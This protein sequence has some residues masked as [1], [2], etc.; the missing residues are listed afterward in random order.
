MNRS[1]FAERVILFFSLLTISLVSFGENAEPNSPPMDPS[2]HSA[3]HPKQNGS[4]SALEKALDSNHKGT[5]SAQSDGSAKSMSSMGTGTPGGGMMDMMG[6]QMMQMMGS[7]MGMM[8]AATMGSQKMG[9]DTKP[10]ELPGFPGYS[11]IY[12]V[13]ATGFFLDHDRMIKLSPEQ[14]EKL[15]EIKK[16]TLDDE[17]SL[18]SRI[19][20]LEQELW[21]LTASDKPDIGSIEEKIMQIEGLKKE[22]RIKFIRAV[23]EAAKTLSDV[24]KAVLLGRKKPVSSAPSSDPAKMGGS[25]SGTGDM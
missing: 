3:H 13:G 2:Q 1:I 22:Q 14:K 8:G 9:S 11:H 21:N 19:E 5:S 20:G 4:K 12:H 6:P 24:Q 16:G 23:G 25:M 7:M 17:S 10:S 15:L 18:K